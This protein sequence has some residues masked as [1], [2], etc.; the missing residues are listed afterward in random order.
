MPIPSVEPIPPLP[1]GPPLELRLDVPEE[2]Q[3]AQEAS[4][5]AAS[6]RMASF[7]GCWV[8]TFVLY[9]F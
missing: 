8:G 1:F 6:A 5:L 2:A 4:Y 3:E 9:M 7:P